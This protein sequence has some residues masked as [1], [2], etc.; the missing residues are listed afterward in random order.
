MNVERDEAA[1]SWFANV[2]ANPA[3][4]NADRLIDDSLTGL[5]RLSDMVRA[6]FELH[7]SQTAGPA[8]LSC[9]SSSR[10]RRS[11]CRVGWR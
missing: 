7:Q 11:D 6:A 1:E 4:E 8:P 2:T 5:T 9:H 3:A 10:R